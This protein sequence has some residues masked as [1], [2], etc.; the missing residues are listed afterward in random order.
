MT[1][2]WKKLA[3]QLEFQ[4]DESIDALI[5]SPVLIQL[6]GQQYTQQNLDRIREMLN[7]PMFK[8]FYHEMFPCL[9]SGQS[10]KYPVFIYPIRFSTQGTE[11]SNYTVNVMMMFPTH[12]NFELSIKKSSFFGRLFRTGIKSHDPEFNSM[13]TVKAKNNKEQVKTFLENMSLVY[14]AKDLFR[15]FPSAEIGDAGVK[16]SLPAGE[17]DLH[18]VKQ[19]LDTMKKVLDCFY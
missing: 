5:E 14:A 4:Y 15:Q 1:E 6:S 18:E 8:N 13:V 3:E 7:Q 17:P 19:L 12:Y 9:L 10:G 16:N 2:Y 11:S